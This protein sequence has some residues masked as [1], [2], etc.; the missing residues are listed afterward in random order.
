MALDF[1]QR[2]MSPV[3]QPAASCQFEPSC[4]Q[5]AR[6]AVKE[7]GP[8]LGSI[9]AADR[10]MRCGHSASLDDYPAGISRFSDPASKNYL[11]GNGNLWTTVLGQPLP[12]QR[13][14]RTDV[15]RIAE[16]YK[17][18]FALARDKEYDYSILELM[19]VEMNAARGVD[20]VYANTLMALDLLAQ[21]NAKKALARAELVHDYTLPI[22][23]RWHSFIVS[24]LAAD[25]HELDAWNASRSEEKAHD[26]TAGFTDD[27][28][29]VLHQL[30]IYSRAKSG[31]F[32]RARAMTSSADVLHSL[33]LVENSGGRS[34]LLAGI[35]GTVL[36]GSGYLYAGRY[37]EA[38]SAFSFNALLGWGIYS[39]F[40]NHNTGSG[41]LLS[42]IAV[43]FYLGNIAGGYNAAAA[44]NDKARANE[45]A[46]LRETLKVSFYFSADFVEECWAQ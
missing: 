21:S 42:T 14:G 19:R 40:H 24:Y 37:G 34:P 38:F 33:N 4:S 30:A 13:T 1:Y 39:L 6:E 7:Y 35:L 46:N 44:V 25:A 3:R 15:E 28:D 27:R 17:L 36:P 11:V 9:L 18:A 26:S 43:P 8:M 45:L 23:R 10:L 32:D 16:P 41:I 29:A 5:F 2:I 20:R 31:E 12:G 22:E